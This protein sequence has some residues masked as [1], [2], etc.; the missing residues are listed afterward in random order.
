MR[1]QSPNAECLRREGHGPCMPTAPVSCFGQQE[2]LPHCG[3]LAES[4]AVALTAH[5]CL[6]EPARLP[7]L[8]PITECTENIACSAPAIHPGCSLW[9][10]PTSLEALLAQAPLRIPPPK[11]Q[12]VSELSTHKKSIPGAGICNHVLCQRGLQITWLQPHS[13]WGSLETGHS[14]PI[15]C[16]F[17]YRYFLKIYLF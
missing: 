10:Q 5:T 8:L 3:C 4:Q 7:P 2:L 17:I 12:K 11:G 9:A 15:Q 16:R 1:F 14:E 13:P 6:L